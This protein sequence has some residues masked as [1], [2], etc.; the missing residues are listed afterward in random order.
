MVI[1]IVLYFTN[2]GEH[3]ALHKTTIMYRWKPKKNK[4]SLL[5]W[6]EKT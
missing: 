4:R 3:P 6:F 1:F 5:V 2:K